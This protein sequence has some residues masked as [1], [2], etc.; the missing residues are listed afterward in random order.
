MPRSF[1]MSDASGVSRA[2]SAM[3]RTAPR[4]SPRTSS[5]VITSL[6]DSSR[7]T[8]GEFAEK[9]SGEDVDEEWVEVVALASDEDSGIALFRTSRTS[10]RTRSLV[11]SSAIL[12]CAGLTALFYSLAFSRVITKRRQAAAL[13]ITPAIRLANPTGGRQKR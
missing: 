12:E 13:Q 3:R 9:V 11:A 4:S 5:S 1:T 2:F 6:A 7:V 8:A 10:A